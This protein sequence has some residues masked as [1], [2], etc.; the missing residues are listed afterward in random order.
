[1]NR[2]PAMT[3]R[4]LTKRRIG[5]CYPVVSPPVEENQPRT[6][7]WHRLPLP[8]PPIMSPIRHSWSY[9]PRRTRTRVGSTAERVFGV[10]PTDLE[11]APSRRPVKRDAGGEPRGSEDRQLL[12]RTLR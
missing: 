3:L 1:M 9:T 2:V 4:P 5:I 12:A 7:H 8:F 6:A 11:Q 10:V